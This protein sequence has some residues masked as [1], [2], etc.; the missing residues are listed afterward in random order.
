MKSAE[1]YFYPTFLSFSAN[2][3]S[4]KSFLVRA[5]TLGLLLNRLTGNYRENLLL[6]I[7]MQ[8]SKKLKTFSQ[9]FIAFLKST[10]NFEHFIKKLL[11]PKDVLT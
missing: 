8:F 10:L 2:L 5:E 11:T 3:S 9:F 7:Q 4:K 6:P 1:K